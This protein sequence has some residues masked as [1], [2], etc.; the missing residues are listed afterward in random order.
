[1]IQEIKNMDEFNPRYTK[2]GALKW[3]RINDGRNKKK[4]L[5]MIPLDKITIGKHKCEEENLKA[6]REQYERTH[7]LVPV[8]LRNYDYKLK[9]GYELIVLAQELGLKEIPYIMHYETAVS[10]KPYC[11]KNKAIMDCQG[12]KIYV[13]KVAYNKIEE[14]KKMCSELGLTLDILPIYRFRVLDETGKSIWKQE[15]LTLNT[16]LKKLTR[17]VNNSRSQAS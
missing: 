17:K 7:E 6:H 15:D 9:S 3:Q 11:N 2:N 10:R 16:V 14:C 1:M 4:D 12:K 8:L 5:P 13:T